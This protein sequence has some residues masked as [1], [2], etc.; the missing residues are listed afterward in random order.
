MNEHVVHLDGKPRSYS[1]LCSLPNLWSTFALRDISIQSIY[2]V[3]VYSNLICTKGAQNKHSWLLVH[4]LNEYVIH[5]DGKPRSWSVLCSSPNLCSTFAL[6]DLSIQIIHHIDVFR[7]LIGT[8]VAKNKYPCFL[9]HR[10]NE[11]PIH[12]DG[13]PRSLSN[14]CSWRHLVQPLHLEICQFKLYKNKKSFKEK[15]CY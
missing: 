6:R 1:V 11:Y 8:K 12:L 10:L 14:S 5:L 2:H 4:R 7:N 3:G 15:Q 13:K 9:V